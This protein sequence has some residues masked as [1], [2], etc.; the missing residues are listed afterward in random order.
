MSARYIPAPPRR[1]G[2]R[3]QWALLAVLGLACGWGWAA[4]LPPTPPDTTHAK[5]LLR[6][7]ATLAAT[8]TARAGQLARQALALSTTAGFSYGQAHSWLQLSALAIIG[9]NQGRAGYYGQ[10]AQA[11]AW[12]LYQRRPSARLA[13]L[14]AAIANNRGNVADRQGRYADAVALYLQAATYLTRQPAASGPLSTLLMVYTN[15]GNSFLLLGQSTQA[16]RYWREAV[17]LA[18]RTGPTPELLPVYLQLATLHLQSAYLD[19]ARQALAAARPLLTGNRLYASEYFGTLGQYYLRRRQPVAARRAFTQALGYAARKGAAGYQAKLLLGLGQLDQQAGDQG[20]ARTRL[21]QSLALTEQLGDPQ[22]QVTALTALAQLE[23]QAGQGLAALRYYR[24]SRQLLDTLASATVQRQI[25]QLET[26]FRTRQQAQQLRLLQVAKASQQQALRQQR[27]LSALYL[28]LL[29]T[30]LGAGALGGGLWRHRRHLRA[31]QMLQAQ[32]RFSTQAMLQGQEDERRRLARDLHDGLGGQLAAVRLYL[33]TAGQRAAL[34]LEPAQLLTQ[35]VAQLDHAI[36][37]L[38]QVARN[39]MPEALLS[40]GLTQ[41]LHD[42]CAAGPL[43]AGPQV[44]L[45]TYGF[46][47]RLAPA[48]EV[49][50]YRLVQELLTNALRHAQAQQ[51]LVQLMRHGP[52]VQLVV[53]D[54]G[55]GFDPATVGSG[56]GLRSVRAR[57]QYLKG[58]LDV[59]SQP[60]QGTTISIELRVDEGQA[61]LA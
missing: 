41:A 14:L 27:Q 28:A 6:Q 49:E 19:S 2:W 15:L 43:A 29:L 35:A 1:A 3:R 52:E 36:G 45:Q 48:V 31:Q 23:E 12:P 37:E 34:P 22:Q 11:L 51:V 16:A 4:P 17:A 9:G 25:N 38:R 5:E 57:V 42:L 55:R 59:H 32:A 47:V 46:D 40:F 39:L 8:D 21:Q 26:Q 53:E 10:R 58:T 30:L 50:L 56:V 20:Q 24:R 54:D 7:S 61:V 13:R 33:A 60:G 44:Q 18:P